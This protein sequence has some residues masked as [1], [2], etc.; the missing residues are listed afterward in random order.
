MDNSKNTNYSNMKI[1]IL[2]LALLIGTSF[3]LSG[4]FSTMT[5]TK[6]NQKNQ[7]NFTNEGELDD[8]NFLVEAKSASI[9]EIKLAEHAAESGYSAA[10]VEY[11][12]ET[13]SE[14]KDLAKE[15]NRAARK[16]KIKLPDEMGPEHQRVYNQLVAA[17]KRDFDKDYMYALETLHRDNL[18]RYQDFATD[19]HFDDVRSFAAEHLSLIE[20]HQNMAEEVRDKLLTTY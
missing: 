2:L 18:E 12:K 17:D 13:Y 8:A 4:C 9:L 11:S 16:N 3:L 7:D 20:N 6:A 1:N 14:D 19:G 10:V 5:Y 15:I